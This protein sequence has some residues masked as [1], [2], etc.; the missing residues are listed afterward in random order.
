M[1]RKRSKL[2][3]KLTARLDVGAKA[4]FQRKKSITEVIPPDVTRARAS[5]WLDL[6]SPI[7]EWA[8]LKGDALRHKRDQLRIQQETALELLAKSIHKKMEHQQ[9]VHPLPPKILVPALEGASLEDP[10]SPLV[11]WW[12]NLLVSGATEG[13]LRPYFVDLMKTIGPE[14]AEFLKQM[15]DKYSSVDGYGSGEIDV[16]L[17]TFFNL[18]ASTEK[19]LAKWKGR[20]FTP[21]Q[22]QK[23]M[24]KLLG[25]LGKEA[26]KKGVQLELSIALGT[27]SQSRP[28]HVML[29]V[30]HSTLWAQTASLEVCL[31]LNILRQH[32]AIVGLD[33]SRHNIEVP[34][35]FERIIQ[36]KAIYPTKLGVDFLLA[37]QPGGR[38]PSAFQNRPMER[39]ESEES[40]D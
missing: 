38:R 3:A 5:R 6:I 14:E 30:W 2:G 29:M 20:R 17:N 22:Y 34:A 28:V 36:A 40:R 33:F 16:R 11:E 23:E 27:R 18:R 4:T 39:S 9:V 26:E 7:T 10:E 19:A 37:C 25:R 31:A 13:R 8:G 15:W 24:W 21:E 12:A 1:A 35:N 32:E